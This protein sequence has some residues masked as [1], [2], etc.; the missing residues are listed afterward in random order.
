[1][2]IRL[3]RRRDARLDANLLPLKRSL[4]RV[5]CLLQIHTPKTRR[6]LVTESDHSGFSVRKK[7]IKRKTRAETIS[8][9][10]R[11]RALLIGKS[12]TTLPVW[13]FTEA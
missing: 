9:A 12:A 13:P 8:E 3:A 11:N 1:M 5:N 7:L 2:A 10:S 6:T 4:R